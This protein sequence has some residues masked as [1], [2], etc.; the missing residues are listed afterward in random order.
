MISYIYINPYIYVHIYA[1]T[2]TC[3]YTYIHTYI[4]IYTFICIQ[5]YPKMEREKDPPKDFGI[6][7]TKKLRF[8]RFREWRQWYARF[9][10][11]S[12]FGIPCWK[13]LR[14]GEILKFIGTEAKRKEKKKLQ[15]TSSYSSINIWFRHFN[16]YATENQ[17]FF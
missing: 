7:P 4:Y 10:L 6:P 11:R 15:T 17:P 9:S 14:N 2:Y 16:S 5:I 1:Y 13:L 8:F 3:K 12:Y